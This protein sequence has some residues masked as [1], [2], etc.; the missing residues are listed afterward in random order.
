M[1]YVKAGRLLALAVTSS[2]PSDVAQGVPT[3]T[4]LG[5]QG[6]EQ[7]SGY[8]GLYAPASGWSAIS[9]V[10][11]SRPVVTELEAF[12][13][14]RLRRT[15]LAKQLHLAHAESINDRDRVL[16]DEPTLEFSI[17]VAVLAV[18]FLHSQPKRSQ[19]YRSLN[20]LF[21]FQGSRVGRLA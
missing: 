10:G 19:R 7:L 11:L 14:I 4:E 2:A 9:A 18:L 20:V 8:F 17:H 12:N 5:Y 21:D 3:F 16:M 6:M 13:N 1:T 15:N